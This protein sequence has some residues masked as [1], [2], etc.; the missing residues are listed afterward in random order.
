MTAADLGIA[1]AVEMA[2]QIDRTEEADTALR[3][4]VRDLLYAIDH[5]ILTVDLPDSAFVRAVREALVAARWAHGEM[6]ASRT[7]AP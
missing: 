3:Q 5:D 7:E 2:R 6:A 4:A 1:A